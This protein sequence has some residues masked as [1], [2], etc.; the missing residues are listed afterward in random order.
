MDKAASTP[1]HETVGVI[2]PEQV[3]EIVEMKAEDLNAASPEAATRIIEGT[4]RSMGVAL[5]GAL[6][7][8]GLLEGEVVEGEVVEG[9]VVEG[10]GE[11][12]EGSGEVVED[13]REGE[14]D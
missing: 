1:G 5:E 7:E 4:A 12:G 10:S 13:S 2:T 6:M 14:E 9:E 3:Q 11:V 8:G